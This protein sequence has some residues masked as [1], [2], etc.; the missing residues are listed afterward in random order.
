MSYYLYHIGW[1]CQCSNITHMSWCPHVFCGRCAI[2]TDSSDKC[3]STK[4][5]VHTFISSIVGIDLKELGVR[6]RNVWNFA[7]GWNFKPI[8]TQKWASSVNLPP[9]GGFQP[10]SH[11]E[12]TTATQC[13]TEH[14]STCVLHVFVPSVL[15]YCWLGLLTCKNR[16]P[17][18]LYCV[19]G[20]VK[21]CTIQSNPV[22]NGQFT[23][24]PECGGP[25]RHRHSQVRPR[26]VNA[27]SRPT[28]LAQR[29]WT[30][31]V[32]AGCHGPSVSGEQ[33]TKL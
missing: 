19:G 28:P 20:D 10:L 14:P 24:R 4:T 7:Q 1:H 11:R 32:Q 12:W 17:Y 13:S 2:V 8:F 27:D 9:P 29:S 18:N 26:S 6:C 16:L 5:L 3:D 30:R 22:H 33:S 15:W 31:G 25:P 23:T 21:H